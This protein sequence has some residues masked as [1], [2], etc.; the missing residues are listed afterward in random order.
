MW[1]TVA[2]GPSL[3]AIELESLKSIKDN[4]FHKLGDDFA[5]HFNHQVFK[6]H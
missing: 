6:I 4:Q 2:F 1:K 3:H 5:M